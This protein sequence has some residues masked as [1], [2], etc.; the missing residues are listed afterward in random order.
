MEKPKGVRACTERRALA[1][2]P[3]PIFDRSLFL[4]VH[5]DLEE[6]LADSLNALSALWSSSFQVFNLPRIFFWKRSSLAWT[7]SSKVEFPI[8]TLCGQV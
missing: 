2:S 8:R 1:A 6:V 4:L 5:Q 7:E 3:R